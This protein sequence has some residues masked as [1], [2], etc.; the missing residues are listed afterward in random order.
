M[1]ESTIAVW[2]AAGENA[3]V[4]AAMACLAPDVEVVS[5]LTARFRF[6]GHGHVAAMLASAFE[7]IREI[8]FHTEVG[9]GDTWALFYHG[10]VG[11]EAVEE[12]QLLR[13]NADGLIREIT[14]FGRPLP[15]LTGVMAGIGPR[16]LRRQRQPVLARLVMVAT[17]PLHAMT[18]TGERLL[19]PWADPGRRRRSPSGPATPTIDAGRNRT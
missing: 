5:P 13:L 6:Q 18:R 17:V 10:R 19:L 1:G 14:L 4:P 12:A 11:R 3:D 15:A 7:V 9:D 2:R 16:L 8:R